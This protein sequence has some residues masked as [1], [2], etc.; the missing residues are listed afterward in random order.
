[1]VFLTTFDKQNK[2]L[3]DEV[4]EA[5]ED[6]IPTLPAH[7]LRIRYY[8][9]EKNEVA[10]RLRMAAYAVGLPTEA[11]LSRRGEIVAGQARGVV[12]LWLASR[13]LTGKPLRR[14]V[15]EVGA[16]EGEKW[17]A[18]DRGSVWP[19]GCEGEDPVLQWA[20]KDLAAARSLLTV[21]ANRVQALVSSQWARWVARGTTVD[22]LLTAAGLGP[23][24]PAEH[25]ESRDMTC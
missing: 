20:P 23:L 25:I 18:T 7:A 11:S 22:E 19:A 8:S 21:P 4:R 13:G 17:D 3:Q 2:E 14:L 5:V 12:V 15:S 16:P 1:M 24:G 9:T 10:S 6:N